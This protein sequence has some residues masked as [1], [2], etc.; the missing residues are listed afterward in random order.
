MT[1]HLPV[2]AVRSAPPPTSRCAGA[3]TVPFRSD[4]LAFGVV[5]SGA[6]WAG[7]AVNRAAGRPDSMDSPGSLVWLLSPLAAA[8]VLRR[9]RHGAFLP[10]RPADAVASSGTHRT[11]AW[12]TAVLVY[13]A[14]T[15]GALGLGR[16]AGL[17][18]LSRADVA[19]LGRSIA[20]ALGPALVKNLVEE[21]C[22]RGYLTEEL[23]CAGVGRVPLNLT[24]GAVWAAWHVPY[25]LRFLPEADMR[26]V[27]DVPR[28]AFA[29][30]AAGVILAWTP[31]YT[32]VYALTRSVWPGVVM[33]AVEDAVVN[34]SAMA[35]G[36]R[37]TRAGQ[38]L[39]SPVVGAV[40]SAAYTAV[41][42]A[43]GRL[44]RAL[45]GPVR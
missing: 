43:L 42:W 26:A 45:R 32:E 18:D 31:L 2:L 22:W 39:V 24:V 6:G 7:V 28:R 3:A 36:I 12:G 5:A 19:G 44:G 35:T 41:G 34:P 27:L 11:L 10:L 29:A 38:W 40:T 4:L 14:V 1:P 13:P 8:A 30:V 20:T 37:Y 21:S 17:V 15:A 25:Y 23:L 16:A 33:H 9:V